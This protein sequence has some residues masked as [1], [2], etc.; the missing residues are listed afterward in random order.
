[1]FAIAT[2][3]ACGG[4]S[5]KINHSKER[6]G[7]SMRGSP[8]IPGEEW[9][10]S[11]GCG[12]RERKSYINICRFL[13]LQFAFSLPPCGSCCL[14]FCQRF[15]GVFWERTHP[16]GE[17]KRVSAGP[18]IRE[19]LFTRRSLL[20]DLRVCN[21]RCHL[22]PRSFDTLQ[23]GSACEPSYEYGQGMPVLIL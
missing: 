20:I 19:I 10:V 11:R 23:D 1:M 14:P 17:A 12:S 2:A 7:W 18:R 13:F 3:T 8:R 22:A 21:W 16:W 5:L 6:K 9:R 4:D 15:V